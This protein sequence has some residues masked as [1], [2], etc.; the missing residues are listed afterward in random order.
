MIQYHNDMNKK[1]N[2]IDYCGE[3]S[4]NMDN[5]LNQYYVDTKDQYVELVEKLIVGDDE[6]SEAA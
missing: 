4:K 2:L 1:G 3:H 5:I 6:Y